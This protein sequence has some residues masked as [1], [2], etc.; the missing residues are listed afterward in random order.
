ME[1]IVIQKFEKSVEEHIKLFTA[2][3]QQDCFFLVRREWLM[4]EE[5]SQDQ[6]SEMIDDLYNLYKNELLHFESNTEKQLVDK[7]IMRVVKQLKSISVKEGEDIIRI[8]SCLEKNGYADDIE[9]IKWRILD[10]CEQIRKD[11]GV[12]QPANFLCRT[13][14]NQSH[15]SYSSDGELENE[16][17]YFDW[18]KLN[19]ISELKQFID[20]NAWNYNVII[21]QQNDIKKQ[22]YYYVNFYEGINCTLAVSDNVG[23]FLQIFESTYGSIFPC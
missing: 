22:Y 7:E 6:K 12:L 4:Y 14:Q 11:K 18:Y 17:N 13:T 1:W 21:T 23:N 2:L 15:K 10:T 3:A 20:D 5:L 9:Q 8:L 16:A 19:T